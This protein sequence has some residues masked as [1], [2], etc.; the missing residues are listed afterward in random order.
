[1]LVV[2]STLISLAWAR[3]SGTQICK[4]C[5]SWT[6]LC[7]RIVKV[8]KEANAELIGSVVFIL[9]DLHNADGLVKLDEERT[10]RKEQLVLLNCLKT[11][12]TKNHIKLAVELKIEKPAPPSFVNPIV[13]TI[14]EEHAFCI[15]CAKKY[16][17]GKYGEFN[18]WKKIMKPVVCSD[19][20][21]RNCRHIEAGINYA[22]VLLKLSG[23]D[24]FKKFKTTARPESPGLAKSEVK[25]KSPGL[26][27]SEVKA[28]SPGQAKSEV[29]AES[30]A[31]AGPSG[32]ALITLARASQC[33]VCKATK[34]KKNH[35]KLLVEHKIK[36]KNSW[37][38]DVE[39]T[40]TCSEEFCLSCA[41]KHLENKHG[42]FNVWKNIMKPVVYAGG[43]KRNRRYINLKTT[44]FRDF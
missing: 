33:T 41:R 38:N 37:G 39:E 23:A 32:S 31:A 6:G 25:A 18:V 26:A 4:G 8:D 30:P 1:M 11:N 15:H 42:E 19:G 24:C 14:T 12:T 13:E 5:K 3:L 40:I 16:L 28:K 34:T 21:T 27:K 36:K 7:A 35:I 9:E 29:K 2:L 10:A 22:Q 17:E 43:Q 20:E 44:I